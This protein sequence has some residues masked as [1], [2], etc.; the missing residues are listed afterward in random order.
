M[1]TELPLDVLEMALWTR[2]GEVVDGLVHHSDAGSEK[3]QAG[4]PTSAAALAGVL[5]A[6][7]GTLPFG[8]RAVRPRSAKKTE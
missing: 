3:N 8:H 6:T 7:S 2:A 4:D 5:L 1:P